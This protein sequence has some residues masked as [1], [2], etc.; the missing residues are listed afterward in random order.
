MRTH[1]RAKKGP[2]AFGAGLFFVPLEDGSE[3]MRMQIMAPALCTLS[4]L[5][6][7]C[8]KP[9]EVGEPFDGP[10]DVNAQ[11]QMLAALEQRSAN[12][13]D[14]SYRG[15]VEN[16]DASHKST[17]AFRFQQPGKMW[18]NLDD[19][20]LTY[21]FDGTWLAIIDHNKKRV[22][23]QDI[24]PKD[25]ATRLA[26][27]HELFRQFSVEGW[28]APLLRLQQDRLRVT[29]ANES[30]E[31]V[32]EVRSPIDD[33]ELAEVRYRFSAP[34]A[35]FLSKEFIDKQG[36]VVAFTKV[37]Q[38]TSDAASK[39]KF[40][41]AWEQRNAKGFLRVRLSEWRVNP[42]LSPDAFSSKVPDGYDLQIIAGE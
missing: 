36:R 16:E 40:P 5:C 21:V 25:P 33:D 31:R 22:L 8:Q 9:K 39:G 29:E 12:L 32:W 14:F 18:A 20:S 1:P 4:L 11:A 28:R 42:G 41:I 7:A 3:A 37:M 27:L 26:A 13:N 35:D 19:V 2:S 6:S 30:S 38:S 15:V 17:F 34:S 10:S 23:K 24:S